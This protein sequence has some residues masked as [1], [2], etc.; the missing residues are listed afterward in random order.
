M[1]GVCLDGLDGI[2]VLSGIATSAINA[3][4]PIY[5]KDTGAPDEVWKCIRGKGKFGTNEDASDYA[6]VAKRK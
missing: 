3:M 5:A 4:M 2:Y 1:S 6:V